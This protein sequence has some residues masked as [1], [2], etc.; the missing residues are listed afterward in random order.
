[1]VAEFVAI[2][3][4]GQIRKLLGVLKNSFALSSDSNKRK[5]GLIGLAATSIALGKESEKFIDELVNPVLNCLYDSELRV[6]YFA[7]ESLYNVVKVARGAILPLFPDIFSALSHLVN[8]PDQSV[9]NGSEL[10]DRLLKVKIK[11]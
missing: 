5:G 8:D 9:K 3:N 2:K 7:S 4:Y 11:N 10:L 6:R 1:M